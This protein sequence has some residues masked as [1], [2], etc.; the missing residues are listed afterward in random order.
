MAMSMPLVY[1]Q[2]K[3]HLSTLDFAAEFSRCSWMV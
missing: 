2:N 3:K 1:L